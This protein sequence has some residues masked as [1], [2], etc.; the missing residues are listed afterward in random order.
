LATDPAGMVVLC[1][2]ISLVHM[3]YQALYSFL[4]IEVTEA[5]SLEKTI[6]TGIKKYVHDVH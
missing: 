5:L 3:L 1:T 6:H 2:T 4:A